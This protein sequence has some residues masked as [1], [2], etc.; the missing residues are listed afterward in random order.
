MKEIKAYIREDRV[1]DVVR[2][3]RAHG[4]RA[5]TIVRVVPMGSEVEP[6][7]VDISSAAPVEH[8]TP[9]LKL[10]LVCDDGQAVP[11]A[12]TIRERAYTGKPGDGV[13]FVSD[14]QHALHIRTGS[15]DEAAL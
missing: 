10:E 13:I 7:F 5:I 3:L 4:A 14:V 1:A 9:M 12:G 15:K 8:Y 6:E 2:G 11:F